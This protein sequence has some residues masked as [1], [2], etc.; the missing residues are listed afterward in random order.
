MKLLSIIICTYN[1]SRLLKKCLESL[2]PQL[3][4]EIEII[5]IDNNSS[6]DTN[7]IVRAYDFKHP[8][9]RYVFEPNTGL[10]HARNRGIKE[11]NADWILYI[12]DDAIAFPDL[13]ERALYLVKRGDFDCVGGM[14]YGYYEGIKPKWIPEGFGTKNLYNTF[15]SECP[16]TIPSGGIA[17]Y[18]KSMLE[19][20]N[21]FSSYYGM[22]G[23]IKDLGEESELQYRAY[24]LNYK[25]WFDPDLKIH[26]LVKPEYTT[27]S[28]FIK[29]AYLQGKTSIRIVT[30]ENIISAFLKF[31]KS[32][33]GLL[34]RRL[35]CN[36]YFL[37]TKNNYY[38][39]NLICDSLQ[40][41]MLLLGKLVST[42]KV[43]L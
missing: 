20:L 18:R 15:L 8:N 9:I 39:Q 12:D 34:F 6:D 1:R 40:P 22:C 2:L 21:G 24:K 11:S 35:P 37:T 28:W 25:M 16:Y 5:V 14:Y 13:V 30:N 38:W 33:L 42:I 26:H 4:E 7:E 10:S 19:C 32:L 23:K 36:F 31:V 41:N 43:K 3:N 17:I 29:H 27:L